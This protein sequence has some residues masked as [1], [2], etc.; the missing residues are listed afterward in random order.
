M[1]V[2]YR[3][4]GGV[5]TVS[6][7]TTNGQLVVIANPRLS[8]QLVLRAAELIL[9]PAERAELA[10]ALED[11]P[12]SCPACFHYQGRLYC[13]LVPAGA[14]SLERPEHHRRQPLPVPFLVAAG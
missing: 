7:Q 6:R 13:C 3:T 5:L 2:L 12:I 4:D 11:G 8:P 14:D 9:V 1:L 10:Q